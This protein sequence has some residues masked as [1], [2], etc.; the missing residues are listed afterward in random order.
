M[1]YRGGMKLPFF[2]Q[3]FKSLTQPP[4]TN[5]FPAPHLPPSVSDYLD[6]VRAGGQRQA[7]FVK[8]LDAITAAGA[9]EIVAI[10]RR[11]EIFIV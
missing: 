6:D 8:M 11:D 10:E 2:A 4:A 3:L 5:P 1:R 7:D 9:A